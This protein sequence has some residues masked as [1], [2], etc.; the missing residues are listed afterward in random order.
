MLTHLFKSILNYMFSVMCKNQIH[1]LDDDELD[2]EYL[3]LLGV[4]DLDLLGGGERLLGGLEIKKIKKL[5]KINNLKIN[6]KKLIHK[7]I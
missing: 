6:L 4:L 7:Y 5:N 1:Y 3:L 2:L